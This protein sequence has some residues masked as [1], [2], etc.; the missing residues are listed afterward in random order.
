MNFTY[1]DLYYTVIRAE[2]LTKLQLMSMK[3]M[4]MIL[5]NM[6]VLLYLDILL[7]EKNVM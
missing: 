1:Y 4:K 7:E 6:I 3:I 2:M 5:I